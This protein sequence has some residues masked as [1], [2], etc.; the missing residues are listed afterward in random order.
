M[1]SYQIRETLKNIFYEEEEHLRTTAS[2]L[3][4]NAS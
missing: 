1:F 4:F 2:Y 3:Y